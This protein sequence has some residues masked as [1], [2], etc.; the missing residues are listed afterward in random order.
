MD[1][2]IN[3]YQLQ[4][5]CA[6]VEHGSYSQAAKSMLMTQ[7]ALSLQIKSLEKKLG[8]KLFI[9]KGNK[10]E[11]TDVGVL[12]NQYAASL[13]SLEKQLRSSVKEIISGEAGRIAIGS[14]RPIGR[15]LLPNYI[16]NFMQQFP[17]VEM[18]TIYDNT[19]QIYRYVLDEKVNV[20][21]VTWSTEQTSPPKMVKHLIH[22]DY[23][24]LVCST[25]SPWATWQGSIQDILR[26]APLI[27]SL[28]GT[29]HGEMIHLELQRLGLD[30][31]DYHI[32]LR[33]DDIESIKMAVISHLGIAFLP[34][35]S[36]ERELANKELVEVPLTTEY[37]PSLDCY[38]IVKEGAYITPTLE[39]FINFTL[40]TSGSEFLNT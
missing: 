17:T 35:M 24:T 22:K 14:N 5:F 23:W 18:T 13:L 4:L 25:S 29:T 6:V 2:P 26:K 21:F 34:R 32:T 15:Y 10:M 28:P 30:I 1:L 19:D 16:L 9:R 33:L 37:N 27:G 12:T 38:L 36:I 40:E 7:P 39:K 3:L 20:G 11:L 8:A 31:N